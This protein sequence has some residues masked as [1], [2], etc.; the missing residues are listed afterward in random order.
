MKYLTL[1]DIKKHLNIDTEFVDDDDYLNA[2]GDVAET[3]VARHIDHDLSDLEEDGVLPAPII[4]A[5]KLLIG[6]MYMNRE[7]VTF[8]SINK[9]PQSYEYLL[10]T[11]K[12]RTNFKS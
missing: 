6:N 8:S 7:S 2:L 1:E 5:C 9:I 11:Y 12:N 3:M 10:A 4:H